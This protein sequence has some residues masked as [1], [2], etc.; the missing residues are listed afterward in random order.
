MEGKMSFNA[1]P[2]LVK[3]ILSHYPLIKIINKRGITSFMNFCK[4]GNHYVMRQRESP[5]CVPQTLL[6]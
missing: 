5:P 3:I 4:R 1:S 2:T 6:M